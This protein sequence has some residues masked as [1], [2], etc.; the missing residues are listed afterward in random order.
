[1]LS[2]VTTE[3]GEPVPAQR[4]MP[5]TVEAALEPLRALPVPEPLPLVVEWPV[6]QRPQALGHDGM[7]QS[8]HC[9]PPLLFLCVRRPNLR[10]NCNPYP[11]LTLVRPGRRLLSGVG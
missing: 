11:A 2:R 7:Q 8:L 4:A 1:M 9:T 10:I 6:K 3:V 5:I